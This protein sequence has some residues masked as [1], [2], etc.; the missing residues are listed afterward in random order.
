MPAGGDANPALAVSYYECSN[1]GALLDAYRERALPLAQG[2][3]DDGGLIS[4]AMLT[5]LWADEWNVVLSRVA[6]DMPALLSGLDM[7][8]ERVEA[9]YGE[10][11]EGL[12][13]MLQANCTAHKDNIYALVWLT[14]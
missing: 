13:D 14:D 6:R 10:D 12:Q 1:V 2:V 7:M 8:A 4:E 5:H 9:E 11:D 3:V